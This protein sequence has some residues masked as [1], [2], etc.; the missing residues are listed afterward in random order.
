MV[1]GELSKTTIVTGFLRRVWLNVRGVD[2][3]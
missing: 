2:D 1:P 3:V